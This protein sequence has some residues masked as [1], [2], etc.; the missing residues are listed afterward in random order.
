[1][2][3]KQENEIR[4]VQNGEVGAGTNTSTVPDGN[5]NEHVKDVWDNTLDNSN[6][7]DTVETNIS[8][9]QTGVAND[10]YLSGVTGSANGSMEFSI[11]NGTNVNFNSSHDHNSLYYTQSQLNT[12]GQ[13]IVHWDNIQNEPTFSVDGH[14]HD[15]LYV[16]V[17]ENTV[18]QEFTSAYLFISNFQEFLRVNVLGGWGESVSPIVITARMEVRAANAAN[19]N[20]RARGASEVS[21]R[22]IPEVYTFDNVNWTVDISVVE[23]YRV[24]NT[25]LTQ[26][27]L[28]PDI[29]IGTMTAVSDSSGFTLSLGRTGA[30]AASECNNLGDFGQRTRVLIQ[31]DNS[32][33]SSI[34]Q[35]ALSGQCP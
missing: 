11:Q 21:W 17:F 6:R 20:E 5:L 3:F 30:S 13:S 33:Y 8:D 12:S 1:M 25:V 24:D 27:G 4:W 7:L 26:L 31:Y 23:V 18:T 14:T 34:N 10:K 32:H 28:P 35:L 29:N 9:L 15:D 19:T 22:V 2:A 16:K